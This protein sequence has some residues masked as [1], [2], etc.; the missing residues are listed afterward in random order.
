MT[1]KK[2]VDNDV[3]RD[4]GIEWSKFDQSEFNDDEL[5]KLFENYFQ[6]FPWDKLPPNPIGADIGCGSGRWAKFVAPRVYRL[7]VID[8]SSAALKVAKNN[9]KN[10]NNVS[11]LNKSA[12]EIGELNGTLDFAYSL[13][14][15]HHVPDTKQAMLSVAHTL[16]PGAPFLVY[17]YYAFDNRPLWFR[18]LWQVS[19]I[20]RNLISR[21]PKVIK[22]AC[23]ELIALLIYIPFARAALYFEKLNFEVFSWPLAFYREKSFYVMRTDALDRFGTRLEKRFNKS[24]INSLLNECNLVDVTFMENP[25]YWCAL[26]Y[27]KDKSLDI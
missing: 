16:K 2:N 17:L 21:S 14:V 10:F 11:F 1:E 3:V 25:P 18:L 9:L 8:P 15:L 4:F 20:F 13:G 24:E 12:D 27:K 7:N 19:D 23:C 6:I 22:I 26:A 5:K